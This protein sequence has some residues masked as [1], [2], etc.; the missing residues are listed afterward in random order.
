MVHLG[1]VDRARTALEVA[2]AT[3]L[4]PVTR[5][6]YGGAATLS[7]T[8]QLAMLAYIGMAIAVGISALSLTV[9]TVALCT[10]PQAHLWAA[11]PRR[12]ARQDLRRTI[13]IEAAMPLG[14]T[15]IA[16]AGLGFA[17]AFVMVKTLG[18]GLYFTWPDP[19]YWWAL[20]GSVAVAAVA[21][22][23]S[24]GVVRRSTEIAS[25]RFE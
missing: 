19:L 18:N 10:R 5:A 21:V 20:L 4:S 23:G 7:L 13:A 1:A 22:S 12:H 9:A 3:A 25:T 8:Y 24:F 17:L 2:G 6:E 11:S 15:L 16:S 14:V